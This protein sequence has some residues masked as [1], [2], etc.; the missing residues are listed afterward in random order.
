MH[1][2]VWYNDIVAVSACPDEMNYEESES[3]QT[4]FRLERKDEIFGL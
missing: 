1:A 2:D 3:L 4:L